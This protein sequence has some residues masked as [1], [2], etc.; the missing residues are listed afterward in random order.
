MVVGA[1]IN[2]LQQFKQ[3][4]TILYIYRGLDGEKVP[5]SATRIIVDVAW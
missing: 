4:E 2:H 5:N 1:G 3:L